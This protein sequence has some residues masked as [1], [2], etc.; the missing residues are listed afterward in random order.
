MKIYINYIL[1]TLAGLL[2]SF[3]QL[4][5]QNTIDIPVSGACGMCKN[6]I[7][8]VA[9]KVT[10]VAAATYHIKTQMLTVK[11]MPTFVRQK[12]VDVLLAIGHDAD[13]QI[14][15]E[16][17]YEA[18]HECCHY[19]DINNEDN[20]DDHDHDH[21]HDHDVTSE[22]IEVIK[23]KSNKLTGTVYEKDESGKLLPVIGANIN[24]LYDNAGTVTDNDGK[25]ETTLQKGKDYLVVSYIGYNPDTLL[26]EKPGN[27]KITIS[28][29][30]VLN[31][32]TITHK[33][34]ST[35][36]SYLEPVKVYQ[37]SSKEL[38]KAACCNLAESFDTTPAIDAASTDA[39]TGI[40]KIEML[41][42]AGPYIQVTTENIPSVRGLAA[43]QGLVY[44]PGPWVESMQL[45]MGAGSVV[46]GFESLTGQINVELRKPCNNDELYLNAYGNQSGR[47]E[48]NTFNRNIVNDNWSTATLLHA[49]M[50][51][52]RMDENGDGFMDSPLGKQVGFINRWKFSNDE[53]QEG[54]FGVK[55][56]Y[57]D[58]ISGEKDFDPIRSQRDKVWGSDITTQRAE[59]WAKRG[60]VNMDAP[61]K[62]LGIQFSGIY[63]DQKAQFG[64]RR[65]DATQK[66]LYL[67]MI[68]QTIID[69]TN[70]QLRMGP[71]F[72][73][74]N[75]DELVG[76]TVYKRNE[77]VPGVF[78]EY[79]FLGSEQFTVLA[80]IRADYHN[81]FGLFITP[82]LNVRYAPNEKTVFRIAAGRGQ[83]TAS[84]FAENI[85]LFAS[86]RIFELEGGDLNVTPYGLDA[87][88]AW[89]VGFSA[90]KEIEFSGKTLVLSADFNRIHFQNQI[91]V[92]LER[93]ART[94]VF[95][96]LK[97]KSYSNSLQLQA[98]VDLTK[99]FDLR[100]AYRY[101]DVKTTYG[102]DLL[103]K[104]LS[105][106]HRAFANLAIKVG[107]GWE[108]DYT[109][110][111]M[112]KVRIPFT[113]DNE[114]SFQL[115]EYSD[116]YILSNV[117]ITKSWKNNFDL[118]VGGE[119]IFNYKQKNPILSAGSPFGSNFDS[120][121]VWGP[122]MGVNVYI[123]M[124]YSL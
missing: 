13:G 53:G 3:E 11:T 27:I 47:Y 37:I 84:I 77:W 38:L 2:G 81:N 59:V 79:T 30:N 26:I 58:N 66:S 69:N 10:G 117:Q 23:P 70:H 118:Y 120:S 12:L 111:R 72:Q 36:I 68:Y 100:L 123:G 57:M 82:R 18:L 29:P 43:L 45:N 124:R 48:M 50:R 16:E 56:T 107:R 17:V 96:N 5:A 60:F 110:N 24:W 32:V 109:I 104:P 22:N 33:R 106:P 74:D 44:I 28:T 40:R 49:S 55:L 46:N 75:Y 95:Y 114:A 87:E 98:D 94:V 31:E 91:V 86:N 90:T 92:D 116:P 76:S 15:K 9:N 80:G 119:N 122:I 105:S 93:S 61:Y 1:I 99:W 21:D 39:V 63:H 42:L 121:L 52:L 83:R 35:E 19:R 62:S 102:E 78:G 41:G 64:L 73:Y 88:V 103:I 71:S 67:N 108:F 113:G 6:R 4:S 20:H 54:Q 112:S 7:E 97:G 101:N 89:N 8:T 34:R 115:S 25:F 14:A 65:Y 85:G 51:N